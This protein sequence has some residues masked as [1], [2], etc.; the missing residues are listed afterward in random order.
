MARLC[1]TT[2]FSKCCFGVFEYLTSDYKSCCYL[3]SLSRLIFILFLWFSNKV[4]IHD[5]RKEPQEI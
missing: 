3:G 4:L 5:F 1:L 2:Y